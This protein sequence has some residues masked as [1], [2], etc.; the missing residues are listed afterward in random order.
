MHKKKIEVFLKVIHNRK[1]LA[2]M[3]GIKKL[4]HYSMHRPAS[5]SVIC[6]SQR[7]IHDETGEETNTKEVKNPIMLKQRIWNKKRSTLGH[8]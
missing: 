3:P 6:L 4:E 8:P 7:T 1:A 2:S 5:T